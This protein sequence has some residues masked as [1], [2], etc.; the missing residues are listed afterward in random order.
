LLPLGKDRFRDLSDDLVVMVRASDGT[1]EGY[2][3]PDDDGAGRLYR[4]LA[5][6]P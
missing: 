5:D 2:R 3:K 1:V 6:L 4:R